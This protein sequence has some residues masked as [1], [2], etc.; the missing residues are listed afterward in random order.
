MRRMS[1]TKFSQYTYEISPNDEDHGSRKSEQHRRTKVFEYEVHICTH[2][3]LEFKPC[4]F[5]YVYVFGFVKNR[6]EYLWVY[7]NRTDTYLLVFSRKLHN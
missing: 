4:I 7:M 5:T 1:C 3:R 2:I 6:F